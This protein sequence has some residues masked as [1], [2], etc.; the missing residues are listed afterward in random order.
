M[1]SPVNEAIL[2]EI[3]GKGSP[4]VAGAMGPAGRN[5]R[6]IA[7][8]SSRPRLHP[9]SLPSRSIGAGPLLELFG[10]VGCRIASHNFDAEERCLVRRYYSAT[11]SR[12]RRR[13]S[14]CPRQERHVFAAKARLNPLPHLDFMY[15]AIE[16]RPSEW[17]GPPPLPNRP[18]CKLHC[19]PRLIPIKSAFG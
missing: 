19:R 1:R 11:V 16:P 6:Y 5:R 12:D 4:L 10:K 17:H 15:T 8:F 9:R 2:V 13:Q 14:Q 7:F 3:P 18:R